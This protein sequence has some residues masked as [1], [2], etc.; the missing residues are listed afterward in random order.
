MSKQEEQLLRKEM[1]YLRQRIARVERAREQQKERADRLEQEN[2]EL[3]VQNKLLK[4]AISELKSKLESTD[5]HKDK[6][7]GMIFKTNVQQSESKNGRKRGGQRG[8]KGHGRRKPKKVDQEKEIYLSHCFECGDEL[9]Q[10]TATYERVVEDIPPPQKMV[11]RYH[12]Q[13]QWCRRCNKE[14]RA[15]PQGTLEGFRLGLQLIIW[16]L[17]HKYRLRTPLAKMEEALKEQYDI[18]LSQGG[19]QDILHRLKKRFGTKYEKIIKHIQRSK[20]KHGDETGWRV[21]GINSWCWLFSSKRA[22]CY[23]IEETRGKGVPKTIL[24]EK[25]K[26]V[27]IRDDYA[28]YE[29]LGME[30]Q[31][32][33]VH[34]LRT[35]REAAGRDSASKEVIALHRKLKQM[36]HELK[37]IVESPFEGTKRK[38]A[39]KTY[40][41]KLERI[42]RR[43]YQ[44]TDTQKVQTRIK[45]Q[46]G[47]L[48]TAIK[49][50]G[51]PL[52]N[53]H[54]EQQI[55][56]MVVTRK[57]SGGSRS[58]QGAATHA[59]NMSIV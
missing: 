20:V 3:R 57:I 59:V 12:I 18:K 24:G 15:V 52:T 44:H 17:F 49:Y 23:T 14:V 4:K 36:F 9:E 56:P 22:A 37:A 19:I 6:L 10:T 34:L 47:Q 11:T 27:L 7:A 16:I 41:K 39:Y 42:Q 51:V 35:S 1:R 8:H 53:N 40:L 45:R 38:E 28:S 54:A 13:R 25:P 2:H 58:P 5:A 48:L 46:G 31:S 43:T 30:Q 33:W 55:R 32:C 29:H 50:A 21:E 26:G